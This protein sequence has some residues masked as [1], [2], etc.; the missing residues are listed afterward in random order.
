MLPNIAHQIAQNECLVKSYIDMLN[1]KRYNKIV[2]LNKEL[3]MGDEI[4]TFSSSAGSASPSTK[5]G[6]KFILV[7]IIILFML[8]LGIGIGLLI[9]PKADTDSNIGKTD[10][11]Y[12]YN[13]CSEEDVSKAIEIYSDGQYAEIDTDVIQS[14]K[15]VDGYY[16]D[17]KCRYIEILYYTASYAKTF[18]QNNINLYSSSIDKALVD[19]AIQRLGGTSVDDLANTVQSFYDFSSESVIIDKHPENVTVDENGINQ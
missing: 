16:E 14:R 7:A 5:N 18:A 17:A 8:C 19:E 4:K 9:A 15:S 6:A 3:Q 10:E 1:R 2:R 12:Q 11:T 13:V